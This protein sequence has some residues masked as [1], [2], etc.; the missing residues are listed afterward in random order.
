MTTAASATLSPFSSEVIAHTKLWLERAVIGLNLCPFAK[1]VF[2]KDQ[3]RYVVSAAQ[4]PEELLADLIKELEFLHQADPEAVDTTLLIHPDALR[5]FLDYN[6]F[7]DVAD[8]AVDELELDGEIQVASF[9][10]DYQFAGT[11]VDDISNYT[12]RAPYPTLHLLREI[13]VERAVN[14][15][16]DASEIFNKNMQTLHQLGLDGWQKVLREG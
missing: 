11:E 3:I 1:A 5:D 12:N 16:P 6:D 14:A 9:H 7:L 15:F 2:I 8:A 13:S 10:P 4:T